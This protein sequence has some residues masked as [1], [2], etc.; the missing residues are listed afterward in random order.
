MSV[1]MCA[2]V[3]SVSLSC[4]LRTSSLDNKLTAMHADLRVIRTVPIFM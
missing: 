3:R 4:W 1:M 2:F